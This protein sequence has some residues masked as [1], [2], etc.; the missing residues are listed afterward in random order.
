MVVKLISGKRFADS[1]GWFSEVYNA[2]AFAERGVGVTFVQDNQSFSRA[3]GTIRGLHFQR[4]PHAQAKL[5][6]CLRGAIFD[7]AVDVRKGSP[8][9]GRWVGAE[10]SAENGKQLF[11]PVGF[12]HGFFTLQADTEIFYK[13]SDF[14]APTCDGGLRW[15]DPTICVAWPDMSNGQPLLSEKDEKLPFLSEFDSPFAYDGAPLSLIEI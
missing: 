15:N 6:R 14:Y 2:N 4:P 9:Y 11:I 13:V 10:L 8:T 1:R 5:V 3:Q 12:A 7:V